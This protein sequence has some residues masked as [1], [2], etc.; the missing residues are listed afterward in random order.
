LLSCQHLINLLLLLASQPS[1]LSK[2]LILMFHFINLLAVAK[3]PT[4]A[5]AAV[6]SPQ[7]EK[8]SAKNLRKLSFHIRLSYLADKFQNSPHLAVLTY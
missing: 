8:A 1:V 5:S 6:A 3:L 4:P 2:V 7:Q